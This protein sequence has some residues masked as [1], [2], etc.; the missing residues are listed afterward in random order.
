M[1]KAERE[2]L[3]ALGLDAGASTFQLDAER[4]R[5]HVDAVRGPVEGLL[6]AL[7]AVGLRLDEVEAAAV[8]AVE[9]ANRRTAEAEQ[10]RVKAVAE[11]EAAEERSRRSTAQAE[12]AAAE[13][14][15]AVERAA[16]AARQALQATEALGAARQQAAAAE[17]GRTSAEE[18]TARAGQRAAA[19]LVAA[20]RAAAERDAAQAEITRLRE[21]LGAV[22][23]RREEAERARELAQALAKAAGDDRDR[24]REARR[25]AEAGRE[26]ERTARQAAEKDRDAERSGRQAAEAER[27]RERSARRAAA[28]QARHLTE[29][30]AG[31]RHQLDAETLRADELARTV[32]DLRTELAT[33]AA[34]PTDGAESGDPRRLHPDDL[35]AL[36]ALLRNGAS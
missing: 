30:A 13:R 16:A 23:A 1:A 10:L 4:L 12:Q 3:G 28:E 19:A 22:H 21:E 27:D 24:E 33:R 18:A 7:T 6:A 25:G 5:E 11:K 35:H 20:E 31:L 17:Q 9:S 14:S 2:A 36:A 34:G 26:Q 32:A 8:A 29:T 15:E